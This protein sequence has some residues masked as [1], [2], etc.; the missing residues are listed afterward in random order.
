MS[1]DA[2]SP[3]GDLRYGARLDSR[4][5]NDNRSARVFATEEASAEFSDDAAEAVDGVGD[6]GLSPLKKSSPSI[7]DSVVGFTTSENWTRGLSCGSNVSD[8]VGVALSRETKETEVSAVV[9][10][11][12]EGRERVR[13]RDAR[14]WITIRASCSSTVGI[15]TTPLTPYTE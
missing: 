10:G 8:D 14:V 12:K 15:A 11:T 3:F 13:F 7:W 6:V 5:Q 1:A 4:L 9:E 2:I